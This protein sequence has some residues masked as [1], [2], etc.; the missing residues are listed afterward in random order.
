[1][2]VDVISVELCQGKLGS[3][4]DRLHRH[5][6]EIHLLDPFQQASTAA[7]RKME[8][9]PAIPNVMAH[10]LSFDTWN[11]IL[12]SLPFTAA[13]ILVSAQKTMP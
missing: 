7:F 1:M 6:G 3:V 11:R 13:D 12:L 10:R 2:G 5:G 8:S 9:V 4:F